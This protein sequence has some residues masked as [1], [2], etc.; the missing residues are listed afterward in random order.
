MTKVS[1]ASVLTCTCDLEQIILFELLE[2]TAFNFHELI[3]EKERQKRIVVSIDSD[4]KS[5]ELVDEYESMRD[6]RK[7]VSGFPCR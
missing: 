4:V 1:D 3:G 7:V 5:S 2:H 6:Y